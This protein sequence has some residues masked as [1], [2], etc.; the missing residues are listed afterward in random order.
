MEP[1][2][3]IPANAGI[4]ALQSRVL[5][6]TP[7]PRLSPL[8]ITPNYCKYFQLPSQA[9][10]GGPFLPPSPLTAATAVVA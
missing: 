2:S 1:D 10:R 5:R 9:R 3:V 4:Q 8:S 7:G 6:G